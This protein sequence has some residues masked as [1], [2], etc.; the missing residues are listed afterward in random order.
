M[1]V[2][3]G[4]ILGKVHLLVG[5]YGQVVVFESW[6]PNVSHILAH[7][8]LIGIL[9]YF[10]NF[11]HLVPVGLGFVHALAPLQG[12]A[13]AFKSTVNTLAACLVEELEPCGSTRLIHG[14]AE[15]PH[16]TVFLFLGFLNDNLGIVV[17]AS[18]IGQDKTSAY[19]LNNIG[20]VWK[21]SLVVLYVDD[22]L[23]FEIGAGVGQVA[24]HP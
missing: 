13:T 17:L 19:I 24:L 16:L 21:W 15:L 2:G 6:R 20:E 4:S 9:L 12:L 3:A 1:C 8:E 10:E 22:F 11:E 18:A 7:L 23:Q 5:I 14:D